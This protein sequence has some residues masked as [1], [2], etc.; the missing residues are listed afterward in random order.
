MATA[1][2]IS[3]PLFVQLYMESVAAGHT[4]TQFAERLGWKY[5][6]VHTRIKLY[7]KKG[8]RL[9]NLT[10]GRSAVAMNPRLDVDSLNDMISAMSNGK[11]RDAG[12]ASVRA[13]LRS[14]SA[15]AGR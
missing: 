6:R 1:Q 2:R 10:P 4:T 13:S 8:I 9:P 11:I 12:E 15:L 14:V 5:A 7:R 3:A